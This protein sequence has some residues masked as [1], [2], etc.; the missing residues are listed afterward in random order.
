VY[1]ACLNRL[2]HRAQDVQHDVESSPVKSLGTH[3]N[4][5]E[6]PVEGAVDIIFGGPPWY[7]SFQIGSSML[8]SA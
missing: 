8:T 5:P 3:E 1:D 2:L 4:L 7:V 6:F